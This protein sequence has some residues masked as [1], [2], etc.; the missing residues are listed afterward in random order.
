MFKGKEGQGNSVRKVEI[1]R[2][3]RGIHVIFNDKVYV[4]KENLKQ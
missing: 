1:A 3:P 2:Y 4:N